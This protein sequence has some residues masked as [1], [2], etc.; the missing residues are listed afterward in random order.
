MGQKNRNRERERERERYTLNI[1]N[2]KPSNP[3]RRVLN[4]PSKKELDLIPFNLKRSVLVRGARKGNGDSKRRTMKT[5]IVLWLE[6]VGWKC[7][8]KNTLT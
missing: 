8:I 1:N 4:W 2:L 7:L 3:R 6:N 5:W